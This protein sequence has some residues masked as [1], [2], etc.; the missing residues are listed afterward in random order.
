EDLGTRTE[1]IIPCTSVK[2]P[3][4]LNWASVETIAMCRRA[5]NSSWQ[6]TLVLSLIVL[7]A[8]RSLVA[9]PGQRDGSRDRPLHGPGSLPVAFI[10]NRGQMDERVRFQARDGGMAAY[11]TEDAFVLQFVRRSSVDA[12]PSSIETRRPSLADPGGDAA[13]TGANVFLSFEG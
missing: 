13:I 1:S 8:P 4:F 10:E 5:S 11:F 2:E 7:V 12:G 3:A 9:Q 6:I